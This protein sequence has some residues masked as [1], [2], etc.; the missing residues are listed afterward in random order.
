[1]DA[2]NAELI[3]AEREARGLAKGKAEGKARGIAETEIKVALTSF[4]LAKSVRDF[5]SV[6][7]NLRRLKLAEDNIEIALRKAKAER[8]GTARKRPLTT[9]PQ[10]G[11][12]SSG[13]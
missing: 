5:P 4:S 2:E 11:V 12:I 1:L 9:R 7:E 8:K 13:S 3:G 6:V 10:S